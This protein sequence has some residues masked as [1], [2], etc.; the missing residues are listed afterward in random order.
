MGW[1]SASQDG[2]IYYLASYQQSLGKHTGQVTAGPKCSTI[3]RP[4]PL[5]QPKKVG[6]IHLPHHIHLPTLTG[7]NTSSVYIH[8]YRKIVTCG[9]CKGRNDGSLNVRRSLIEVDILT[10]T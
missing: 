10:H 5:P 6:Q 4:N 9:R 7:G 8:L 2:G 3:G 1:P